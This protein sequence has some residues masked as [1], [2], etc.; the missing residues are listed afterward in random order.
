MVDRLS[1]RSFERTSMHHSA[2]SRAG[3]LG[4]LGGTGSLSVSSRK[5]GRSFLTNF[6]IFSLRIGFAA[7]YLEYGDA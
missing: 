1:F 7:E 5:V 6:F 2:I 3:L 4:G